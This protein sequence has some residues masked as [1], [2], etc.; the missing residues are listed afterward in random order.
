MGVGKLVRAASLLSL[1]WTLSREKT[2]TR[3]MGSSDPTGRYTCCSSASVQTRY[4][5]RYDCEGGQA[6]L[7]D[8]R[9]HPHILFE[10]DG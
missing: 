4:F 2:Y 8:I 10:V 9:S 6:A 3:N 7:R 1:R 5:V